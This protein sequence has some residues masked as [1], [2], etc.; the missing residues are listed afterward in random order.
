MLW[1]RGVGYEYDV[2]L[3]ENNIIMTYY[4]LGV[5][6]LSIFAIAWWCAKAN[7]KDDYLIAGRNRPMWQ[8]LLSKTAGS[9][10]VGFFL[11]YTGYGYQ[12]GWPIT[13]LLVFQIIS[14]VVFAYWAVPKIYRYAREKQFLTMGDFV[15][16]QLQSMRTG[17]FLDFVTSA[18]G[19]LWVVAGFVGGV[20]VVAD[21]LVLSYEQ[22]LVL[23]VLLVG[24]YILVSG[25]RVVLATDVVQV[26]AIFGL[27]SVMVLTLV[28]SVDVSAVSATFAE[29]L[30]VTL[31]VG[32]VIFGFF[33][34][35]GT[36]DRYQLIYSATSEQAARNGLLWSV[37]P[38]CIAFV[39][40]VFVGLFMR[41]QGTAYDP[42]T[43]FLTFINQFT[44]TELASA[45]GV[46]LVAGLMS[47]ADT[48]VYATA[49]HWQVAWNKWRKEARSISI[50]SLQTTILVCM[51]LM[52]VVSFFFRDLLGLAIFSA[53][54]LVALSVPML[55]VIGGGSSSIRFV[56]TVLVSV[57]GVIVAALMLGVI[58]ELVILPII[59]GAISL[60]L[61]LRWFTRVKT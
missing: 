31:I 12:F 14:A 45:A 36:A 30:P 19:F 58:P 9:I 56:S 25:Y 52:G 7:T 15:G 28:T 38:F 3:K 29:S 23:A 10:G 37:V 26:V 41:M 44:Y 34:I 55:Y 5:Y 39:P 47:T 2:A 18:V 40:L 42:D 11:L 49:S 22:S 43:V 51:V 61:P 50:S 6:I 1:G 21:I 24:G 33:T 16:D 54:I 59:I 48:W 8:I 17:A 35:F 32:I 20:K 53:A 27:L 60:L 4:L 46:M 13:L 57:A